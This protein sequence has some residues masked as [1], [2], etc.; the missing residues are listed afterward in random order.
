MGPSS[1][2][3]PWQAASSS[4][5]LIKLFW[6][7]CG[8]WITEELAVGRDGCQP[9]PPPWR[10]AALETSVIWGCSLGAELQASGCGL[11]GPGH[12]PVSGGGLSSW[13][14]PWSL[15]HSSPGQEGARGGPI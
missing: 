12:L 2:A 6:R 11:P 7:G 9:Q 4:S 10:P 15:A 1:G 13:L 8:G 14:T 3:P 5:R